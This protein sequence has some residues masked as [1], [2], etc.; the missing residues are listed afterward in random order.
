MIRAFVTVH[1]I[2]LLVVGVLW[3]QPWIP[4]PDH[5]GE[6]I[7]SLEIKAFPHGQK[8][9]VL[10]A[11]TSNKEQMARITDSLGWEE[12]GTQALTDLGRSYSHI[13]LE[14]ANSQGEKFSYTV[15]FPDN[16]PRIRANQGEVRAWQK[17]SYLPSITLVRTLEYYH[18]QELG[19]LHLV[20]EDPSTPSLVFN[21]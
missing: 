6:R 4:K 17:E 20:Q 7:L 8:P 16:R 2:L 5:G 1:L 18:Y 9:P 12:L 14:M 21:F 11:S 19:K 3:Y 13:V 15:N 10:W